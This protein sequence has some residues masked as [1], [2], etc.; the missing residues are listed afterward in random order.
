MKGFGFGCMRPPKLSEGSTP[1]PEFDN[2]DLEQMKQMVDEFIGQGF[3]YFDTA[4]MYSNFKNEQMLK[5]TLTDRWPRDAYLLADKMSS[6]Y[7][8]KAEDVD[9]VFREQLGRCGVEYFDY[10]LLHDIGT[11]DYDKFTECGC[12]EWIREKK[13]E[14]TA[15]YIGFSTHDDPEF[16][17]RILTEHPEM[18]FVQIQLNYLDWE[19]AGV[20]A[21]ECCEMI[22]KHGRPIVVMEPCKGGTLTNLPDDVAEILHR[23]APDQSQASWAIRFAASQRNV[24]MVLSGVSSLEQLRDNLSFMREFQPLTEEETAL[25]LQAVDK[26]NSTIAI[27]CTSC[28]YCVPGCPAGIPIPKYFSLYNV[29][30]KDINREDWTPQEDFYYRLTLSSASPKKCVECGQCEKICPQH[31]PVIRYLKEVAEHFGG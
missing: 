17:D 24:R 4:W 25:V 20:R 18:E 19:N 12:F 1:V 27:P 15:R 14:G 8:R 6:S 7:F 2:V 26:I 5:A 3:T 30:L 16:I 10:Y 13:A 23:Y 22:A 9:R 11:D 21:R 29:N 31:L 28:A